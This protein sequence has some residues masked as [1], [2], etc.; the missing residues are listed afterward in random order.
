MSMFMLQFI[1]IDILQ[2]MFIS[3]FASVFAQL[4]VSG[5]VGQ[6][7]YYIISTVRSP[8]A[9]ARVWRHEIGSKFGGAYDFQ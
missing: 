3:I 1:G 9:H 8:N 6:H 4:L 7:I 2:F 5:V